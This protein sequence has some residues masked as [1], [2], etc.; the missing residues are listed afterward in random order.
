M[1]KKCVHE[2]GEKKVRKGVFRL[3]LSSFHSAEE[4][5]EEKE[6]SEKERE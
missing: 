5:S 3:L 4:S 1:A 2:E 6:S